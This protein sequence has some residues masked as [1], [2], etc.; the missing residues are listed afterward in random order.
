MD[1]DRL[2]AATQAQ[3]DRLTPHAAWRLQGRDA[4]LVDIRPEHQRRTDGEIPGAIVIDRNQLEWRC[5]PASDARIAEATDHDVLWM[6]ICD[7]G[8]GSSLAAASLQL[9]GLHR[10]T[11]VIGGFRAWHAAGLPVHRPRT[12]TL[13]RAPGS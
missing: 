10:A 8:Y 11:D 1:I 7:E 5:D 12:P 13:P 9:L 6:I 3:L 4:Y 2:L